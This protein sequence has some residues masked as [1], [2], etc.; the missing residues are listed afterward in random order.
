MRYLSPL[1]YPGGKAKLAN[2]VKQLLFRN[3]LLGAHY[4]EPYAGGASVALSLL[5]GEHVSHIHINDL[6]QFVYAFWHSV[7]NETE[8]LCRLVHDVRVTP[9][10]WHKQRTVQKQPHRFDLVERGFATFFLNRTNR[11]GIICS[12]G[13][14]GGAKQ[15]GRWKIDARYNK[16]GLVSRIQ[17][18]AALRNRISLYGEDAAK[19]LAY[20]LPRLPRNT[21][22]YLDPPYYTKGGRRLYANFYEHDDHVQIADIVRHADLPWMVSYDDTP[23]IRSIYR[24]TRYLR[25]QLRYTARERYDGG[26][27]LFFSR[28]LSVPRTVD[29]TAMVDIEKPARPASAAYERSHEAAP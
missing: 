7:L 25:Y 28:G 16:R 13:M 12:G 9:A 19:L 18:I 17:R 10:Q 4:V 3:D 6:D 8:T 2:F 21:F 29:P 5:L 27:V 24:K 23:E 11:S 22:M 15:T 20:L 14:I 1:R 26:E